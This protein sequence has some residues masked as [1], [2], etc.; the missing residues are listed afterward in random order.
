M[1]LGNVPR[2][3]EEENAGSLAQES[4]HSQE[5]HLMGPK[6]EARGDQ[7]GQKEKARSLENVITVQL[8]SLRVAKSRATETSST[9]P[10]SLSLSESSTP[11]FLVHLKDFYSFRKH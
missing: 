11:P 6:L 3:G 9:Q 10:G 1:K 8:H 7:R 4:V 2:P 5:A